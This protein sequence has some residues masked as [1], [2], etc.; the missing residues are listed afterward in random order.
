MIQVIREHLAG[1]SKHGAALSLVEPRKRCEGQGH[2]LDMYIGDT[3]TAE[4]YEVSS[5]TGQ[6]QALALIGEERGHSILFSPKGVKCVCTRI[7]GS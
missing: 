6:Q 4:V 1:I 2:K 7:P 5:R 3:A